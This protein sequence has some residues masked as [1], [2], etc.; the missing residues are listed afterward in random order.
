MIDFTSFRSVRVNLKENSL[1]FSID[2]IRKTVRK[3]RLKRYIEKMNYKIKTVK[4]YSKISINA[5]KALFTKEI[6]SLK[7]IFTPH[8]KN[9]LVS[10]PHYLNR[11][12]NYR[13]CILTSFGLSQYTK[14]LPMKA[15]EEIGK[16]FNTFG[17]DSID[18]AIDSHN[19]IKRGDLGIFGIVEHHRNTSYV[20]NPLNFSHITK[21]KYYDKTLQLR[22]QQGLLID[23]LIYRL[24]LT[25]KTNGK[26]KDLYVPIEE[27]KAIINRLFV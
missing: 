17:V 26:L 14:P 16:L 25:I 2:T 22:E 27:I 15:K 19:P 6:T 8:Y 23:R 20:N 24:E 21:I 5:K 10:T 11:K 9:I 7:Q 13:K 4:S 1:K 12:S 18:L 3:D